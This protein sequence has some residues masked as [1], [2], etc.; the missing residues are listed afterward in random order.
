M[1]RWV[2]GMIAIYLKVATKCCRYQQDGSIGEPYFKFLS[3]ERRHTQKCWSCGTENY[4]KGCYN[5]YSADIATT[6]MKQSQITWLIV[7]QRCQANK[8]G[9]VASLSDFHWSFLSFVSICS[10]AAGLQAEVFNSTSR[11]QSVKGLV[12]H[13]VLVLVP[14]SWAG[15]LDCGRKHHC[16]VS[17]TFWIS[18]ELCCQHL[19]EAAY[20]YAAGYS[21]VS[22]LWSYFRV[23]TPFL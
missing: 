17:D 14:R 15:F 9:N 1:Q 20:R 23:V 2:A 12:Y 3:S 8:R 5:L 10:W 13:Y 18:K 11:L 21:P 22:N 7:T 6:T 16:K 19:W 4:F